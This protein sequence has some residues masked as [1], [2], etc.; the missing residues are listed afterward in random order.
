MVCREHEGG[1]MASLESVIGTEA[2]KRIARELGVVG[3]DRVT[4]GGGLGAS[5][6][7]GTTDRWPVFVDGKRHGWLWDT[8]VGYELADDATHG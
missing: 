3:F 2:A 7:D 1:I 4:L 8:A 6:S 5:P